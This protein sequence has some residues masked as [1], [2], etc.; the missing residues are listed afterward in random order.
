VTIEGLGDGALHP[1]QRAFVEE[2]ALQC[3]F[4]ASGVLMSAAALLAR[5]SAPT[6]GEIVAALERNL[7]RCGAHNRMLRAIRRVVSESRAGSS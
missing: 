2:Q 4:C 6:D 1:L 5:N 3:G 7:C